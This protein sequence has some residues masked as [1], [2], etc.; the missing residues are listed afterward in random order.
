NRA[1]GCRKRGRRAPAEGGHRRC[2]RRV[3]PT[4]G[5]RQPFW[6]PIHH[7]D[8]HSGKNRCAPPTPYGSY[9]M[10]FLLLAVAVSCCARAGSSL[11]CAGLA[12]P[13]ATPLRGQRTLL[14]H[15]K[16][17]TYFLHQNALPF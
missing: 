1:A 5:E 17:S 2:S 4:H 6:S 9:R 16:L 3:A 11:P 7:P 14:L 13:A 8:E 15:R 10:A 12:L